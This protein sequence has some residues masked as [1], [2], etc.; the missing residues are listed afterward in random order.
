[1]KIILDT[2]EQAPYSF[3]K[4]D[5]E[6]TR[7]GLDCGDY[8]LIGFE[9]RIAVERKSLD[10]LVGCLMGEGRKRFERELAKA[11]SY[12]SFTV[13]VEATMEDLAHG[14]YRSQMNGHAA[15]QSIAAF[16]VRHRVNFIF[17]GN[18]AGGEYITYSIMAK[19]ADEI[20]K[21][22]IALSGGP[23]AKEVSADG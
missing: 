1:M 3:D 13:V 10:D 17:A 20:K 15:C 21:R 18:R 6:V 19:F 11:K 14:R 12:E 4:Y 2:R 23:A 22:A 7:L 8:S 16:M 5:V 9:D